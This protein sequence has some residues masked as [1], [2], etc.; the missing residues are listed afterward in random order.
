MPAF[1]K[2]ETLMIPRQQI[3]DDPVAFKIGQEWKCYF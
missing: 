1:L 2:K 3:L